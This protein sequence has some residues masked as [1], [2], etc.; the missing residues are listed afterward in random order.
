MKQKTEPNRVAARRRSASV[1]SSL[2][3]M[4]LRISSC[5][6]SLAPSSTSLHLRRRSHRLIVLIVACE[7]S[8]PTHHANSSS[9]LTSTSE[10]TP[11]LIVITFQDALPRSHYTSR[12]VRAEMEA[13]HQECLT[14]APIGSNAC[15][16]IS[17]TW[18][19]SLIIGWSSREN[20]PE[21]SSARDWLG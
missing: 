20:S 12:P 2:I 19:N 15:E 16:T 7:L 4:C 18:Q 5:Q 10:V 14:T 8:L 9:T 13:G 17:D 6:S 3:Q 11:R 21:L 1:K